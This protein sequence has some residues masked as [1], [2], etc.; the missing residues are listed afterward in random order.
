M[1]TRVECLDKLS[2]R[3]NNWHRQHYFRKWINVW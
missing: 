2:I 1:V 3:V